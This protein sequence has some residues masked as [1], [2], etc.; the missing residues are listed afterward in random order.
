M[1]RT[2]RGNRTP[3]CTNL[4]NSW[5]LWGFVWNSTQV[6]LNLGV[7][8]NSH[9]DWF[10]F[11]MM[12]IKIACFCATT[13]FSHFADSKCSKRW[14]LSPPPN[15]ELKFRHLPMISSD[16]S[17]CLLPIVKQLFQSNSL[18]WRGIDN[19]EAFLLFLVPSYSPERSPPA[20]R[21]PVKHPTGRRVSSENRLRIQLRLIWGK[22]R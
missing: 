20:P 14:L 5:I 12:W 7:N 4:T 17:R 18:A 1:I 11:K 19:R 21:F 10:Y 13:H 22:I 3:L 9:W 16:T 8:A 6:I 15:G 2:W